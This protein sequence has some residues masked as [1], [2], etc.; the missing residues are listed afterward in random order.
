MFPFSGFLFSEFW[1]GV[2]VA[3]LAP[4]PDF[5]VIFTS[6]EAF[7]RQYFCSWCDDARRLYSITL[8]VFAEQNGT[9][10]LIAY[11]AIYMIF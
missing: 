8:L 5:S 4:I 2:D 6:N 11:A 3:R 9:V 10:K 1:T 7:D